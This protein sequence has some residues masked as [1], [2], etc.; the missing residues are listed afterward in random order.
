MRTTGSLRAGLALALLLAGSAG[1]VAAQERPLYQV[2]V[3]SIV[4][5]GVER[6][7]EEGV[8]RV[9]RLR[10]GDVINGPDVQEAIQRLFATGE[11][12]DVTVR[13]TPREPNIFYIEVTERPVIREYRFEGLRHV[14]PTTV[15][16][17]AGLVGGSPLDPAR[18]AR[19]QAL[20][21]AMLGQAGYPRA[22]VDTAL[23]GDPTG[24]DRF[25][26]VFR[27]RE[28]PKLALARIDFVGN[29]ALA[30]AEIGSAM[31]TA[32]E[33][34]F[35]FRSGV[36]QRE[37]YR[38]DLTE[39]IP[40]FYARRGYIDMA[41]LG[42][43]IV[44]DTL[45]GKGRIEIRVQEG[46]RYLLR[47]L[48]IE[49]NR[50]FPT[51]D[52]VQY[53][54]VVREGDLPVGEAERSPEELPP[55]D[56]VA[57]SEASQKISDLYR[58]AGYLSVRVIP[59]IVRVPPEEEG[60]P[61]L[62][63]ARLFIEE[64]QPA[65]IRTV[66][67]IGNDFTHDRVIRK[68]LLTLPGDIYSQQLLI[69]SV[70]NLQSLGFFETLPPDEAIQIRPRED[71]D[72]DLVYRVREKQTG[73]VN[74]GVSA[75][76][77]TGLA[78]FIG[79]DQPNLFGQAKV[80]HFRW[81][82]GGRTQDIEVSYTDPEI[83]GSR[84]SLSIG[85]QSSRD[86]FRSFSLGVRR[87]TGAFVELGMPVFGLRSTRF[88]VGYSLFEDDI[89]DLEAFGVTAA[90]SRQ[91]TQGT[92]STVNLRLVR[93]TRAGGLFPTAGNRNSISARFTGGPLGGD[94]DYGKW[95][96]V[97]EWFA[98]V[99]QIGGGPGQVPI[100]LVLGLSFK[101]GF[102]FGDNPFFVERFF[103]GGTQVGQQLRGFEEATI[104]PRGHVPRNARIGSI[105]RV[106]ESFFASTAQ[107]GV[108]L[109]DNIFTSTFIDAGNVWGSTNEF[110]PTDLLVGAGLGV[111]LVTPFGPIG[112]DYAYGFDRRD[113]LG[114]PDPGW[115]LH[116]RFGR[117]F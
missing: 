59:E 98:P 82:F 34:F 88:F 113:V 50:R 74:F 3:D 12:S 114:R 108:K 7:S 60:G 100:E 71:G 109:T 102:I 103:M 27:V 64:G 10:V 70:K 19:A 32:E 117:L 39:R 80:G 35:W 21:R 13:V 66:T 24:L 5:R 22:E 76:A 8:R 31:Q 52:L 54:P 93:D 28:G 1:R 77:A 89:D 97:S 87:Q 104:T 79:Y 23:A 55:F 106:G 45:T 47:S 44:V 11:F 81:L 101:S 25:D 105:D 58:D 42:D 73:N 57:F 84:K 115:Q 43:T 4:V 41:V 78:G 63:D 6:F 49:N 38:R 112:L 18:V 75:A 26:L 85:A 46:P 16:D 30:D 51:A 92:R 56:Q 15:L 61:P 110:N 20:A 53:F 68:V 91:V 107:F 36:L 33:G 95:E 69:Q 67:I 40:D 14:D 48:S 65:Y 86:Q 17:S 99:G 37:E 96:M 29:E 9:A 94:G 62:V 111:S 90:D 72:I 2:R 83:F 116:F